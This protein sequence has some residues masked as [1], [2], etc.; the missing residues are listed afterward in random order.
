MITNY[1]IQAQSSNNLFA[2]AGRDG[3][4]AFINPDGEIQFYL[5]Y[6]IRE[7]FSEGKLAISKDAKLENYKLTGGKWGYMNH[8]G[9]VI[10]PLQYEDAK[11]FS[12]GLAPVKSQGKYGYIDEYNEEEISFQFDEAEPFINGRASVRIGDNWRMIDVSGKFIGQ[13]NS[14]KPFN[15]FGL[16]V[17]FRQTGVEQVVNDDH[18]YTR[19]VGKYGMIDIDGNIILDTIYDFIGEFEDGFAHFGMYGEY[20]KTKTG[21]INQYGEIILEPDY[22]YVGPFSEGLAVVGKEFPT[23]SYSNIGYTVEEV[24]E[25][26]KEIKKLYANTYHEELLSGHPIYHE[27]QKIEH[28]IRSTQVKYGYI[29]KKGKLVIEFQFDR[30]EPFSQGLAAVGKH[31]KPAFYFPGYTEAQFDS[32]KQKIIE[33]YMKEKENNWEYPPSLDNPLYQEYYLV[34]SR[35]PAATTVYGYINTRGKQAIDFRFTDA[36]KFNGNLA[37]VGIGYG[38]RSKAYYSYIDLEL[39]ENED[40]FKEEEHWEYHDYKENVIDRNGDLQLKESVTSIEMH[41]DNVFISPQYDSNSISYRVLFSNYKAFIFQKKPEKIVEFEGISLG[42]LGDGLYLGME[43]D[44]TPDLYDYSFFN[45]S[46]E[47]LAEFKNGIM[48]HIRRIAPNRFLLEM[49]Y[50]KD[51]YRSPSQ[52][53]IMD[54]SGNWVLEPVYDFISDFRPVK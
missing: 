23:S 16:S 19:S 26:K 20:D 21:I 8:Q 10:I 48:G 11:Q 54:D 53:G 40:K 3:K 39:L 36:S 2:L 33:D 22:D 13:A 45:S 18:P 44:T 1:F 51:N 38:S 34:Q 41:Q 25:L 31:H 46:G 37:K 30:A 42:Y 49:P 28:Y 17:V 7:W 12:E 24:Q 32:L 29:N 6:D 27:Y 9:E 47:L 14:K 35:Q 4:K 43:G 15:Q 52:Y 50:W 5:E